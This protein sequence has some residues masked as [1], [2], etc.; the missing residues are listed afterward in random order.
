MI[1]AAT[2]AEGTLAWAQTHSGDPGLT[3]TSNVN[4]GGRFAPAWTTPT[5][6]GNFN[7]SAPLNFTGLAAN[8][9]VSYIT[10][11]TASSGGSCSGSFPTSGDSTANASGEISVTAI[12]LTGVAT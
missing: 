3:Y 2:G 10:F 7:L 6:D 5:D 4:T 12:P 9:P 11:W 1:A 8:A